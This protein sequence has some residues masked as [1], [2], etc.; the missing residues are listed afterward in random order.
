[1]QEGKTDQALNEKIIWKQTPRHPS[2]V[3]QELLTMIISVFKENP[4]IWTNDYELKYDVLYSPH[5]CMFNAFTEQV[6]ELS[7]V[8]LSLL[9]SDEHKLSFFINVYNLMM[10]HAA[11][12]YEGVPTC[13]L[14]RAHFM[15]KVKYNIG[16]EVLTLDQIAHGVLRNNERCFI[17]GKRLNKKQAKLMPTFAH[18]L[19]SFGLVDMT[20]Q[21]PLLHVFTPQTVTQQLEEAATQYLQFHAR[22]EKKVLTI[23]TF[24]REHAKEFSGKSQA[25]LSV[26]VQKRLS[27]S[28]APTKVEIEPRQ[29]KSQSLMALLNAELAKKLQSKAKPVPRTSRLARLVQNAALSVKKKLFAS[30]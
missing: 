14:A 29:E 18:P 24:L 30:S 1:L 19:T 2:T 28:E 21:S 25:E 6:T 9:H 23:P 8:D 17:F 5:I 4:Q 13:S 15:R 3:V 27:L 7:Q 20:S 10:I 26:F 12:A 11:V 16:G 22:V